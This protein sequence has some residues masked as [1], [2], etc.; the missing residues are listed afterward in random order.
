MTYKTNSLLLYFLLLCFVSYAQ[1]EKI[2]LH[3]G[4]ALY[5]QQKFL[6][7]EQKFGL[8]KTLNPNQFESSFNEANALYKQKMFD[9][10]L[11]IF[12]NALE[13]SDTKEQKA[14]TYHNIGNSYLQ[15]Q[16]IDAAIE[17]YK[18]A[19]RNNPNDEQTRYNLAYAMQLKQKQDQN[20]KQDN[21]QNQ[22]QK[23]EEQKQQN[24]NKKE[25]QNNK[26]DQDKQQESESQN[27]DQES[28][29]NKASKPKKESMSKEDAERMLKAIQNQEN[30]LQQKKKIKLDGERI[31]IEKD[32]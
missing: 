13:L 22:D 8:A 1:Q 12:R 21:K 4:N 15:T 7:A 18:Q 25:D 27:K 26:K 11:P 29:S 23:Q 24:Q 19:L 9:K 2:L 10:A 32:W 3:Q 14:K 28:E 30:K 6:E 5:K 17:S 20:K 16:K 31:R